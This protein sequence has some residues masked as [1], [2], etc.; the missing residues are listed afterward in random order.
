MHPLFFLLGDAFG[1]IGEVNYIITEGLRHPQY[2]NGWLFQGGL[3]FKTGK[4]Q[5][6][7]AWR[8]HQTL[9]LGLELSF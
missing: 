5:T 8:G 2:E 7:L 1:L 3:R 9:T 6:T 4:T